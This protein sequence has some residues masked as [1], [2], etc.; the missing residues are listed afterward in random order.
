[1]QRGEVEE[2]HALWGGVER[3]GL[4][5]AREFSEAQ[6][7]YP[8]KVPTRLLALFTQPRRR[9]I[10]GSS[11]AGS[12][13]ERLSEPREVR[14]RLSTPRGRGLHIVVLDGYAGR[15]ILPTGH[16]LALVR[17][18]LHTSS[19]RSNAQVEPEK[20]PRE[21]AQSLIS[22]LVPSWRPT[23]DGPKCCGIREHTH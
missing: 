15:R 6:G 18:M 5:T 12:C 23:R 14:L 10:L 1:M 19:G 16:D 17:A 11:N 4:D 8:R 7:P 9:G 3:T 22:P 21:R 20:T 2:F 13:I